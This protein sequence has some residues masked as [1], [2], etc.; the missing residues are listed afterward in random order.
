MYS[1]R[2]VDWLLSDT[3]IDSTM[4]GEI[5]DDEGLL[6]CEVWSNG[7]DTGYFY[8]WHDGTAMYGIVADATENYPTERPMDS[9]VDNL[10][11]N[12]AQDPI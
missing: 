8:A 3:G 2:D 6:V 4:Q 11:E 5:L 7:D 12:H 1:W 10:R 9:W